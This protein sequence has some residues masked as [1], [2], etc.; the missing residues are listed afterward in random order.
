M[1]EEINV[2][3]YWR[4]LENLNLSEFRTAKEQLVM[5]KKKAREKRKDPWSHFGIERDNSGAINIRTARGVKIKVSDTVPI[6]KI[7]K[8][9]WVINQEYTRKLLHKDQ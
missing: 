7:A 8:R 5:V 4:G 2:S 1:E 9:G 6:R 3:S